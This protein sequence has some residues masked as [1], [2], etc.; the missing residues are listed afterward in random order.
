MQFLGFFEPT[1]RHHPT[2]DEDLVA[3]MEKELETHRFPRTPNRR[4]ADLDQQ[5]KKIGAKVFQGQ[6]ISTA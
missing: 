3:V 4:R 6:P 2:A 1:M 5:L